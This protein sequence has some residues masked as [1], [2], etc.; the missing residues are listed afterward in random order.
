MHVSE[1]EGWCT[2]VRAAE[3]HL[4]ISVCVYHLLAISRASWSLDKSP[5]AAASR[6]RRSIQAHSAAG[7]T[8]HQSPSRPTRSDHPGPEMLPSDSESPKPPTR[9][10]PSAGPETSSGRWK[11][12]WDTRHALLS[13][14]PAS[15]A[16]SRQRAPAGRALTLPTRRGLPRACVLLTRSWR[17]GQGRA[18]AW[19]TRAFSCRAKMVKAEHAD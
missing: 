3:V 5:S 2:K 14:A 4:H 7:N 6:R 15:S 16:P 17:P 19:S 8:R 12:L 13:R 11:W 10:R 18:G 1:P 9:T